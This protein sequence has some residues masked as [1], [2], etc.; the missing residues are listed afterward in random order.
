[1]NDFKKY[2][3]NNDNY[4]R[5]E[6]LTENDV[7]DIRLYCDHLGDCNTYIKGKEGYNG[8]FTAETGQQ[9]DL[10]NKCWICEKHMEIKPS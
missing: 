1:M 4:I 9:A 6:R 5:P 3:D 10:R 7:L 8:C 2:I